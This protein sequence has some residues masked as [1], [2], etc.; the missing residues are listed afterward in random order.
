M[1]PLTP[2]ERIDISRLYESGE[3]GH[4]LANRFGVNQAT[5]HKT[6][7][8]RNVSKRVDRVATRGVTLKRVRSDTGKD[9][10]AQ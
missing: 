10:V 5:I 7:D 8:R 2:A 1:L 3:S 6:L 9:R 4:A